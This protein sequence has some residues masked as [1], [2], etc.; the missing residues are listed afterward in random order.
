[1]RHAS[2]PRRLERVLI[3]GLVSLAGCASPESNRIL[4]MPVEGKMMVNAMVPQLDRRIFGLGIPETIGSAEEMW[5]VNHSDVEVH[6]D[7]DERDGRATTA[8]TKPGQIRYALELIPAENYVDIRMTIENRGSQTWHDVFAFNCVSPAKAPGFPDSTLH[9][10]FI[11]LDGRP[12]PL[13][14]VPRTVGPRPSVTV[15]PTR[16]HAE[17]LPPFA[18]AFQAT[19]PARSDDSW[20]VIISE[21]GN[22][23]MATTAPDASFLFTNTAF[24][25][26][27][28]APAF[29]D[30]DPDDERTVEAR[31]YLSQGGL[32]D[33]MERYEADR[34]A[35]H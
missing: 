35:R 13:A 25:C 14:D 26:I 33:F 2:N 15:L 10:T 30:I 29:G 5:L 32:G 3:M 19:S 22:A 21:E 8:W 27:H 12:A 23:Y 9:R 34:A 6:W 31:V 4:L 20:V 17:R 28:A 11:S 24:G 7:V 1:M 18:R 16:A